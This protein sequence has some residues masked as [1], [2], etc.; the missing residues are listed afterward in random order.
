MS[1]NDRALL[2]SLKTNARG[3]G[4]CYD[5]RDHGDV[6]WAEK[7]EPRYRQKIFDTIQELSEPLRSTPELARWDQQRGDWS[8]I[9]RIVERLLLPPQDLTILLQMRAHLDDVSETED[10]GKLA[11]A[12][13]TVQDLL[14][15]LT[16]TTK[17][18][19]L[20]VE[21]WTMDKVSWHVASDAL[22]NLSILRGSGVKAMSRG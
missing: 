18:K 1:P 2:E 19:V 12:Q 10:L 5:A 9:Y 21:L 16:T 7:H 20:G 13:H 4:S 22:W 11:A 17:E 15:R 14:A 3:I 8:A 6:A